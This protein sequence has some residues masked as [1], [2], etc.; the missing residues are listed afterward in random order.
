MRR[1][2]K[3]N[4]E[5]VN[6]KAYRWALGVE[7]LVKNTRSLFLELARR[8]DEFGCCHVSRG[9]LA[10]ILG[11]S[12][13]T[14]DSHFSIL[15]GRKLIRRIG[16]YTP[17]QGQVSSVTQI[18]AWP[19]R[20]RIPPA[21]HPEYG[22]FIKEDALD[23]LIHARSKM[24]YLQGASEEN[25][26]HR[27]STNEIDTITEGAETALLELCLAALGPWADEGNGRYLR[28]RPD[29]LSGL[30]N[31]GF[32]LETDV[33]PVLRKMGKRDGAPP[34]LRSWL[35][36]VDPIRKRAEARRDKQGNSETDGL[37]ANSSPASE[38]KNAPYPAPSEGKADVSLEMDRLLRSVATAKR[39]PK[40][41][42]DH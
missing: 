34:I 24:Q 21:G 36:F 28:R 7:G 22:K 39:A 9:K 19:D 11:C 25:S 12:K 31:M 29:T 3:E 5:Y 26:G 23:A 37:G 32:D 38:G 35:Y 8:S 18:S 6:L 10:D 15:V 2:Q 16:R 13:R 33:L 30:L 14:I 41:G 20:T 27:I 1:T 42:D 17:K 40:T 4:S